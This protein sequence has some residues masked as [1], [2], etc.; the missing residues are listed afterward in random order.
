MS[1]VTTRS[2]KTP[3]KEV[4][5]LARKKEEEEEDEKP[6]PL[7]P[8]NSKIQLTLPLPF[9]GGFQELADLKT[10]IEI[11]SFFKQASLETSFHKTLYMASFFREA[12]LK[13][14]QSIQKKKPS[15]LKNY[16]GFLVELDEIYSDDGEQAMSESR[17]RNLR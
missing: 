13:W 16:N 11:V 4:Q 7:K 8:R 9:T 5:D 6:E 15:L 17:L 1:G 14:Y 3:V 10:H 2:G 12:P